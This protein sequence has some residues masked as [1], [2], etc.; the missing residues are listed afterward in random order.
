M[1]TSVR[2]GIIFALIWII[3]NMVLYYAELSQTAFNLGILVNLFLLM[4]AI[5]VGLF[6]SKKE[7][8][9]AKGN[10]IGDF[11]IALQSGIVYA[12]LVS[13]FV[14]LYHEI[15]DPSIRESLVELRVKTLHEAVPDAETYVQLQEDDPTW[16]DKSYDDY[17]ENQEDQFKSV[18]SSFSVFIAHLMGLTFFSMFFAFFVTLILRKIV[19]RHPA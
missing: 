18:F 15:I 1:K 13:G 2:F 17:I 16:R 11:K 8:K 3:F 6:I 12:I 14:Y 9:F 4:A 7:Q 5:A 19:L 10:F